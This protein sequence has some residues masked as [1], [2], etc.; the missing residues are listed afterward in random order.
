MMTLRFDLVFP[1]F[2]LLSG[3]E[4]AIL[5]L[6]GA[7]AEAGHHPR[8]ICHQFGSRIGLPWL[9]TGSYSVRTEPQAPRGFLDASL[10][11]ATPY[12]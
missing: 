1:R 8:I 3:A 11:S 5:G 10:A 7:L 12:F 4:R 2:K 9:E 6:A